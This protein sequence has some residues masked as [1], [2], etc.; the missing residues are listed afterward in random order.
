MAFA[1]LTYR[2]SLRDIEA[3]L[4]AMGAKLYHMG[5]QGK[6]ARSTLAD[7][8]ES[9]DWRIY[10]DF[11]QISIGLAR[12]L[13]APDP[14]GVELKNS[15][16]ALDSTTIDLCRSLFP[17]A[18][19]RKRKAAVKMHTVLDRHG[20]IPT[21]IS[22]TDGKVHDVN[23]LDEMLPEAGA[24]YVMDRGYVDFER[25]YKFTLSSACFV[26]RTKSNVL[27][28]QGS[29]SLDPDREPAGGA[30]GASTAFGA[31][32]RFP[33]S[34]ISRFDAPVT[35]SSAAVLASMRQPR[36]MASRTALNQK[37]G[38]AAPAVSVRKPSMVARATSSSTIAGRAS[39][40]FHRSSRLRSV[41]PSMCRP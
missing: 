2:E 15:L 28:A 5:F 19:S 17:W 13:Y 18:K 41:S 34:V 27:N 29:R 38:A 25:L 37:A 3:R 22:I 14:M 9:R 4:G 35:R 6:V 7:A 10:A 24:F 1:Q 21:F 11:A 33:S 39:G 23:I 30:Y 26:V 8:N 40:L 32:K 31:L 20:K 36:T 16:Y 12:P